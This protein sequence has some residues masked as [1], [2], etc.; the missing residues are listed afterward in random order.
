MASDLLLAQIEPQDLVKFGMIPEF[1]GRVPIIATL[2]D[3]A[4][5]DLV[6]ILTQPKNALVRQYQRLFDFESVKLRF[7]EEA[8]R[9]IASQ[10]IE[11]K[12]GARGLRMILEDL[13][14]DLMYHLPSEVGS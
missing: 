13:M 9:C 6:T 1:V 14:L 11:R 7:Q 2:D 4:E 3:L 8:L 10:A 5:D 12:V